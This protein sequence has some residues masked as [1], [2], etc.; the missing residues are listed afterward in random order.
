MPASAGRK[1]APLKLKLLKGRREG[2]DSGGRKLV[3]APRFLRLPPTKPTDLSPAASEHWDLVVDELQRLEILKPID[4]GSLVI[5][6]EIWSRI[7][8]AQETVAREGFTTVTSQ[9]VGRHPAVAI[10]EA[11]ERSYR[12]SAAEFGLTPAAESKVGS[13]GP[14]GDDDNPFQ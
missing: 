12:S 11:A 7:K 8:W 13:K 9:G 1:S 2:S 10:L 6:C 14:S 3:E 5:L 4:A